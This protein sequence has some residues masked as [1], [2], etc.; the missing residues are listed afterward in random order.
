ERAGPVGR[1]PASGQGCPPAGAADGLPAGVLVTSAAAWPGCAASQGY[2]PPSARSQRLYEELLTVTRP[3][4][5]RAAP[6][7][8]VAAPDRA[9]IPGMRE[10]PVTWR[11]KS[12]AV[13]APT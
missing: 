10:H 12:P 4:A 11:T 5:P 2:G 7:A 13:C 3:R 1:E 6:R 9:L 8:R